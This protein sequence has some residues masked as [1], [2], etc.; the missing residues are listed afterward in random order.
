MSTYYFMVCDEHKERTDAA[1]RTA[2]GYCPLG[3]SDVTLI[4]FIIQHSYCRGKVRI[5]SE[6]D[7]DSCDESF[8]DWTRETVDKIYGK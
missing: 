2:G 6:H 5:V 1:S 8:T 4:P 7:D 3:D